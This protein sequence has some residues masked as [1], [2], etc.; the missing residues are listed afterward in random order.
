MGKIKRERSKLHSQAPS[1]VKEQPVAG[2]AAA[3]PVAEHVDKRTKKQLRHESFLKKLQSSQAVIQR[4]KEKAKS[5]L[6]DLDGIKGALDVLETESFDTLDKLLEKKEEKKKASSADAVSRKRVAS[7]KGRERAMLLETM[8]MQQVLS[9]PSFMQN[10][11]LTL[12]KHL[13][14]KLAAENAHL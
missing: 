13:E 3:A 4:E 9:H 10:P 12:K 14:N 11:A 5:K 2:A 1:L 6:N 7:R 8:Q